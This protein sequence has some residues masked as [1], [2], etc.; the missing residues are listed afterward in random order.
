MPIRSIDINTK[1]YTFKINGNT[2]IIPIIKEVP[3]GIVSWRTILKDDEEY[4]DTKFDFTVP[5]GISYLKIIVPIVNGKPISKLKITNKENKKE[6]INCTDIGNNTSIVH[7]S[8]YRYDTQDTR[9]TYHLE[10]SNGNIKLDNKSNNIKI[11]YS[12]DINKKYKNNNHSYIV[13]DLI[14]INN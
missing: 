10:L 8:N 4:L 3:S 7:I 13:E 1:E 9:V 12:K 11:L 5:K 14:K 6:W 2:K